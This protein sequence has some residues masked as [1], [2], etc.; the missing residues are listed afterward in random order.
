M[1]PRGSAALRSRGVLAGGAPDGPALPPPAPFRPPSPR[2]QAQ[3]E[4]VDRVDGSAPGCGG[5]RRLHWAGG[6]GEPGRLLEAVSGSGAAPTRSQRSLSLATA[7]ALRAALSTCLC[8]PHAGAPG[9]RDAHR[10]DGPAGECAPCPHRGEPPACASL[11]RALPLPCVPRPRLTRH[12]PLP[13]SHASLPSPD[14]RCCLHS[15]ARWPSPCT[16]TCAPRACTCTWATAWPALRRARAAGAWSSRR[17]AA[18]P[19]LQMYACWW[20][21]GGRAGG[22]RESKALLA[23]EEC[24]AGCPAL[25]CGTAPLP[26]APLVPAPGC[27]SLASAPRRRWPRRRAWSSALGA[28]SK[29][30]KACAPATPA[31]GRWGTRWRSRRVAESVAFGAR[32]SRETQQAGGEAGSRPAH[33]PPPAA[34]EQDWVT[35]QP[36][37]IPL[38]GPANRQGRIAADVIMGK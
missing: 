13:T 22:R 1:G 36:A 29:W 12:R 20:V 31:S 11:H 2:R 23:T 5:G 35:E 9:P 8:R 33:R 17:R 25:L 7:V 38:A 14:I 30:T 6:G 19:T 18:A 3:R 37:L 16:P 15:I 4:A 27:R 34:P 10:R 24:P 32:L 28:A 26:T 21:L